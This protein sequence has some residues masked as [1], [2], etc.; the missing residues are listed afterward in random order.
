MRS[1]L[2]G[3]VCLLFLSLAPASLSAQQET[4]HLRV[5]TAACPPIVVRGESGY[6]GLGIFLWDQIATELGVKYELVEFPLGDLLDAI[7]KEIEGKQRIDVGISCLSITAQ[8]EEIVDFSH[9]FHETYTGI[10]VRNRS[11]TEMVTEVLLNAR[12]W[13]AM[14]LVMAIAVLV[15]GTFYLLEGRKNEKLYSMK[16]RVGRSIEA[17]IVGLLFITRGPIRYYEFKTMAA[18]M[19]SALLAIGSTFLIAGITAVLASAFTLETMQSRVTGLNDLR[20]I[21]VGALVSST[22]SRLLREQGIPHRGWD[23]VEQMLEALDRGELDA[24]VADASFLRYAIQKGRET[25]RYQELYV[26]P[27]EL[28][29]QNYG[30]AMVPASQLVESVNRA[31]LQVRKT[32]AWKRKLA[33]YLGE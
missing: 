5:A 21:S 30:L 28:E 1:R 18:R 24:I 22:S 3:Y 31:L 9:S 13:R 2:A 25:G 8:R 10:A 27:D 6:T 29:L 15:G 19:L 17:F 20:D 11:L 12:L 7:G 26:L 14:G 33:E 16:S 23:D 4:P 32:G